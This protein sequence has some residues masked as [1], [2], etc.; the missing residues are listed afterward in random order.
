MA[1]LHLRSSQRGGHYQGYDEL[2][3]PRV[4]ESTRRWLSCSTSYI[5]SVVWQRLAAGAADYHVVGRQCPRFLVEASEPVHLV[6]GA[7][8]QCAPNQVLRRTGM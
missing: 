7:N 1:Y 5:P 6:A 2:A 3:L 4:D 8:L